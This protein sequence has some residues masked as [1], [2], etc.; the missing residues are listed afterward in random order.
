MQCSEI[1]KTDIECVSPETSV[2]EAALKMRDQR[3]GFLPVCDETMRPIGTLTDR[4]IAIRAVAEDMALDTPV[5][6][7]MTWDVVNCSASDSIDLAR[8]LMERYQVSR[9]ICTGE[10]GRIEG[11]ISLSDLVELDEG[12]GAHT[13]RVVSEREVR[14][15]SRFLSPGL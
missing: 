2:R 11:I 13:L 15:D 14:G 8:E 1:M 5:E 7:C 3:I 12:S 6:A 4:D 9:I 10:R